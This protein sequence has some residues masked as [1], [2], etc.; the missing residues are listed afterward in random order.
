MQTTGG[1]GSAP[2][3]LSWIWTPSWYQSWR[4][5]Q[6]GKVGS[7]I[8]EWADPWPVRA[9]KEMLKEKWIR[10]VRG[11]KGGGLRRTT[12][13]SRAH[14][15]SQGKSLA[16]VQALCKW[17]LLTD[18]PFGFCKREKRQ[19]KERKKVRV[20]VKWSSMSYW[21]DRSSNSGSSRPNERQEARK[22]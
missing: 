21:A 10:D 9:A 15:Q 11:R 5:S 6:G 14:F 8:A 7:T 13:V 20:M 16:P 3:F 22:K 17:A 12:G 18:S 4:H 1:Q 2:F 19:R